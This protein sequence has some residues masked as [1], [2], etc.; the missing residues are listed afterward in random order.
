MVV[1]GVVMNNVYCNNVF[2]FYEN[3]VNIPLVSKQTTPKLLYE[4]S[5]TMKPAYA[6]DYE[7]WIPNGMM[8]VKVEPAAF[9][10]T[11]TVTQQ[12]T[13]TA[14]TSVFSGPGN[15]FHHLVDLPAGTQGEI[16]A[17]LSGLNGVWA[18][19]AFWWRVRFEGDVT[20]WVQ[21]TQLSDR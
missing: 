7:R 18:R 1:N 8:M 2:C 6:G 16:L 4:Q 9:T 10:S 13:L 5:L 19:Q 11:F 3:R 12:V 15:N 21:E 20:G 17:S 14:T